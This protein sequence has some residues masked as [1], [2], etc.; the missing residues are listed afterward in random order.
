MT[1]TRVGRLCTICSHAQHRQIDGELLR[2]EVGYKKVAGRYGLILS[3]VQRHAR[4]HLAAQLREHEETAMLLDVA[5]L[6]AELTDLHA[7]V[8][9]QLAL[10]EASADGRLVLAAVAEARRNIETLARLGPLGEIE[11]RLSALEEGEGHQHEHSQRRESL[12]E[13]GEAD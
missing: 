10:A 9:R 2:H 7:H 1:R 6:L 3:S 12:F 11:Q 13:A 8:R 4:T 5:S